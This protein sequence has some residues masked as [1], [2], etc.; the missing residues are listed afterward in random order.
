MCGAGVLAGSLKLHQERGPSIE[1]QIHDFHKKV[2]DFRRVRCYDL[3]AGSLK[4]HPG[5]GSVVRSAGA[6]YVFFFRSQLFAVSVGR[7]RWSIFSARAFLLHYFH[8][9]SLVNIGLIRMLLLS[10]RVKGTATARL[11]NFFSF[12]LGL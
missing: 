3:L 6:Q 11:F 5:A 9:G 1:S 8:C 2:N 4:L 7:A 12:F 10:T